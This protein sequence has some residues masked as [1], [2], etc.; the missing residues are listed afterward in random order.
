[1]SGKKSPE[2]LTDNEI[3][4]SI[5]DYAQNVIAGK[6]IT[7]HVH[8]PEV[9]KSL[10]EHESRPV[11]WLSGVAEDGTLEVAEIYLWDKPWGLAAGARVVDSGVV[12]S[13]TPVEVLD[14]RLVTGRWFYKVRTYG[15]N[16]GKEGW[17]ADSLVREAADAS[18]ESS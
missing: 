3:H 10:V 15:A 11:V 1:M 12:K 14:K 16:A 17:V 4:I 13:G 9:S 6:D 8:V 7:V 2:D 5:D 18:G